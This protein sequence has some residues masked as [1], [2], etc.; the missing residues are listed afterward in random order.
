MA[1]QDEDFKRFLLTGA[2]TAQSLENIAGSIRGGGSD[3][4]PGAVQR[5]RLSRR[6][7]PMRSGQRT[8]FSYLSVRVRT[9]EIQLGKTI[10]G[11]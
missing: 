8:T 7:R 4:S 11:T 5:S 2:V 3:S 10:H 9:N 6:G 1:I